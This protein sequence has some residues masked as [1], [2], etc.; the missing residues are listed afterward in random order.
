[1]TQDNKVYVDEYWACESNLSRSKYQFNNKRVFNYDFKGIVYTNS[2]PADRIEYPVPYATESIFINSDIT[3]VNKVK[4]PLSTIAGI[5]STGYLHYEINRFQNIIVAKDVT[6]K[7][8]KLTFKDAQL[9]LKKDCLMD[10]KFIFE[11]CKFENCIF[12]H[13]TRRIKVRS[14]QFSF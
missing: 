3:H 12:E 1:M 8:C 14:D 7:N 9:S 10:V 2:Y 5:S 11:N 4:T 13:N 6:Y